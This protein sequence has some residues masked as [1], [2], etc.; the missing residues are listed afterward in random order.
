MSVG[1][2]AAR[3]G[4]SPADAAP[5]PS[6]AMNTSRYAES[7]RIQTYAEYVQSKQDKDKGAQTA[8]PWGED[9][10]VKSPYTTSNSF[11]YLRYAR[12]PPGLPQGGAAWVSDCLCSFRSL[13]K[14]SIS[15]VQGEQGLGDSPAADGWSHYSYPDS[16]GSK[17][18]RTDGEEPPG[19]SVASSHFRLAVI[20]HVTATEICSQFSFSPFKK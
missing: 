19:L 17:K 15:P 11:G 9:G 18:M 16:T 12:P 13:R 5:L 6:S 20:S 1:R 4:P 7:Y 2:A 8:R 10:W 14:R 3:G